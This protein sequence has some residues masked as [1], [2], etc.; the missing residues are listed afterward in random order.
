MSAGRTLLAGAVAVLTIAACTRAPYL[1]VHNRTSVPLVVQRTPTGATV[2]ATVANTSGRAG[3]EVVQ[4]Y[5]GGGPEPGAPIRSLRGFQRVHL[6]AGERREVQFTLA[7][8]DL[9]KST[10][11]ISVGGGQPL[12]GTAFVRA[13]LPAA[14]R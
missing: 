4:L 10:Q 1:S 9:S 2:R 11:D 14:A 6:R 7:A 3:D 12:A 8:E 5:V 13:P